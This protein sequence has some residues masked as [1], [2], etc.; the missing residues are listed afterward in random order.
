[1][2]SFEE[3]KEKF[4]KLIA[5]DCEPELEVRIN[6]KYYMI[7]GY[8]GFVTFQGNGSG[9]IRFDSLDELYNTETIDGICLAKD[10]GKIEEMYAYDFED[11]DTILKIYELNKLNGE[12]R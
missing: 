3:V 11:M 2:Y 12:K 6:E 7:I 8:E 5:A 1:M 9:E 10:W 4:D